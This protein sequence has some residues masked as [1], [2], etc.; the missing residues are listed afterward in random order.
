MLYGH[1]LD[2]N[3]LLLHISLLLSLTFFSKFKINCYKY[4]R[5]PF[6]TDQIISMNP[7]V[8]LLMGFNCKCY[9]FTHEHLAGAHT[10][11]VELEFRIVG[12]TEVSRKKN[13]SEQRREPKTNSTHI[14]VSIIIMVH[15]KSFNTLNQKTSFFSSTY[16]LISNNSN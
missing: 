14:M 12:K 8:S 1:P 9:L 11:H 6:N 15:I 16:L 4:N 7:S 10:I 2:T 13:L 5:Q 3:T